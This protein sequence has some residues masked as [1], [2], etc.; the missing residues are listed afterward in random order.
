MFRLTS[1]VQIGSY[2]LRGGVNNV[3]IK[4]SVKDMIDT[5]IIKIPGIGR[6]TG[7]DTLPA[8]SIET[9]KL[10]QEGDKVSILLG[11]N[12]DNRN[13]FQGF[14]RRV[15]PSIPVTIECEGYAWQLRRKRVLKS[16]KSVTLK[17]FLKEL[18]SDTD[19]KLSPFIPDMSLTNLTVNHANALK[20]L[21]YIKDKLHLAV[22][23]QFD[24]LYV[25]L[26]E[27]VPGS[28]VKYRLGYNTIRDDQLK[29]RLASD[30]KVLVRL[31]TGKGKKAKRA[32]IEVGDKDG[33]LIEKTIT[34]V[35]SDA[36]L[37]RIANDLLTQAKYTGY[38]GS[39][40][41]FLQPYCQPC[42]TAGIIDRMYNERGGNYFAEG[43]EVDF[44]TNG[45]QRKVHIGRSLSGAA[46]G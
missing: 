41:G 2:Q 5:A 16:W 15:T 46:N 27:G 14:V 25:G 13:E 29:Y 21:E 8:S 30:T 35:T 45:A 7:K 10:F 26:E 28:R 9:S 19:I 23:F 32:L 33:S 6:V 12:N 3:A 36:D 1:I 20:T 18:V 40:T 43:V 11:Y 24:T 37:K 42:D 39:I 44:G 31:V 22:Y 34:N 17:E 38:E 4:R